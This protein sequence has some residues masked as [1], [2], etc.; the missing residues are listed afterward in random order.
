MKSRRWRTNKPR[1]HRGITMAGQSKADHIFLL[2]TV[3]LLGWVIPG[4]GHFFIKERKRGVIIF[5]TVVLTFL[6]GLYIGSVGVVDLV[7]AWYWF[8]AQILTS[9][10]VFLLTKM[11]QTGEYH[12]YGWPSDI[13]R[14]Y[15]SIA[16]LLNL[17]AVISAVYMAHCGRGEIIGAEDAD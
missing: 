7:G 9:P 15:T 1:R 13:G 10:V 14:I 5:I 16:G 12:S 3:G 6:A 17:L 2:I 8:I 4:G 11:T